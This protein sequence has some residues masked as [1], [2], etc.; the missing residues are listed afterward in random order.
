MIGSA[1][2][3]IQSSFYNLFTVFANLASLMYLIFKSM[4]S[5]KVSKQLVIIRIPTKLIQAY[6]YILITNPGIRHVL[7]VRTHEVGKFYK[8]ITFF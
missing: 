2:I 1:Y 7:T 5:T 3:D 8:D 4:L 6:F